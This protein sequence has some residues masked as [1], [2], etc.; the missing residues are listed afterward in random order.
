MLSINAHFGSLGSK[1]ILCW[2]NLHAEMTL[3]WLVVKEAL[4]SNVVLRLHR[5]LMNLHLNLT[6]V[7]RLK[8]EAAAILNCEPV[9]FVLVHQDRV[10]C[11]RVDI[12]AP[13][14]NTG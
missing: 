8:D 6:T 9:T 11:P 13:S 14:D 12:G 1:I 3:T 10:C 4:N 7:T 5:S 2:P